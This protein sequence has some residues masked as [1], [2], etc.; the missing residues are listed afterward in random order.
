MNF[1]KLFTK[2]ALCVGAALLIGAQY[3]RLNPV[4]VGNLANGTADHVLGW[5]GS[6]V[7]VSQ[8]RDGVRAVHGSSQ[9]ISN[10]TL[11][12]LDYNAEQ[13]DDNDMHDTVTNNSRLTATVAGRYIINTQVRWASNSVGNRIVDILLNGTTLIARNQVP[14]NTGAATITT[15][16]TIWDMAL[17]DYVETRVFQNSGG[18]LNVERIAS[19]APEFMMQQVRN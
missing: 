18:N 16:A 15:L 7:A 9:T 19:H 3:T 5:D 13:F 11:T 17:D 10:N 6:G 4:R 1:A 12:I 2:I 14:T 8:S